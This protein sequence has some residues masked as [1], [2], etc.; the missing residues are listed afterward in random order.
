MAR[1]SAGLLLALAAACEGYAPLGGA[2]RAGPT[3]ARAAGPAMMPLGVPKV[4]YKPPG[5]Y[6]A[7]WVD[8]YNRMFRERILF[9][10]KP[11]DDE[12]ANQMVAIMLYLD[13]EDATKPL[14]M[15]INSPG[16][17][18]PAGFAM[19]DTMKHIK[20]EVSTI[21]IGLAASMGS[22][23]L[24]AGTPGKR[25]ALPHSRTMIHQPAMGGMQGQAEDIKIMAEEILKVRERCV[26]YYAEMSGQPREKV[27]ADLDRDNFMSAQQAADYGLIDRV[28]QLAKD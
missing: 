21:N 7:D 23:L 5:G 17:S 20:T 9:L 10:G 18:V 28:V 26:R 14:Q 27:R 12:M 4:A 3:R 15:Y 22:F 11:I 16:G 25:L 2:A 13:S 24:A 19:F 6:A 1:A 8:L